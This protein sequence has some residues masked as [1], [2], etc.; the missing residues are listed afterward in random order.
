[1]VETTI[2]QVPRH[3]FGL[4]I[5]SHILTQVVEEILI[6]V[7][8][9]GWVQIQRHLQTMLVH[10]V[11]KSLGIR[12]SRAVPCPTSPALGVPVHIKYHH[13]HRN[14]E[15]LYIVH[16]LHKLIRGITL[17][18]AVPIAQ[19]IE[20]WHRLT[21]GHLDVIAQSLLVLM[22]I[23]HEV[24]VDGLL[25]NGLSHPVD[26]IHL[27]VE[28]KRVRAIATTG[29]WRLIDNTP[30]GTRQQT[31]LQFLALVI[32]NLSVESTGGSLQVQR[33]VLTWI[34]QHTT[35]VKH[36]RNAEHLG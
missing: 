22:T 13:I 20:W 27:L 34:P 15:V 24:P 4:F 31:I 6:I 18:F 17:V 3:A 1:M 26:T 16:N 29:Q 23:T 14:V 10:P 35:T 21:T 36:H 2:A 32:A 25:V 12:N 5:Q 7:N 19:H 28:H 9:I 11:D 8:A 30:T 33:I